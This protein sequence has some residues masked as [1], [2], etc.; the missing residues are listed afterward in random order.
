MIFI[1]TL[2]LNVNDPYDFNNGADVPIYV[3]RLFFFF[4]LLLLYVNRYVY[5]VTILNISFLFPKRYYI[6]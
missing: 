6:L 2:Q 1:Y 4:R 3:N 5:N